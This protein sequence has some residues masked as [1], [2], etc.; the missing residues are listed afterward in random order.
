MYKLENIGSIG[1]GN[2]THS[3]YKNQNEN[4]VK[5]IVEFANRIKIPKRYD[6]LTS[7]QQSEYDNKL[8]IL[9]QKFDASKHFIEDFGIVY[10]HDSSY[11]HL[12]YL[13]ILAHE[14]RES[15][16]GSGA[17]SDFTRP[18][19]HFNFSTFSTRTCNGELTFVIHRGGKIMCLYFDEIGNYLN[20]DYN[21]NLNYFNQVAV[22]PTLILNDYKEYLKKCFGNIIEY[23]GKKFYTDKYCFY[24]SIGSESFGFN[25]KY[26]RDCGDGYQNYKGEKI[27]RKPKKTELKDFDFVWEYLMNLVPTHFKTLLNI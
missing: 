8:K 1:Y 11:Q 14:Y 10:H 16:F 5:E 21:I 19:P 6:I 25:Y 13:Y 23:D 9:N 7:S 4:L 12:Q 26:V 24:S 2:N 17:D 18:A 15:F 3:M 20:R 27:I 22:S